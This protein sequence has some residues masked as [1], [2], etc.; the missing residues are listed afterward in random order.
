MH[1]KYSNTQIQS[2]VTNTNAILILNCAVL[3]AHLCSCNLQICICS[4]KLS[5]V[6]ALAQIIILHAVAGIHCLVIC[7]IQ[8]LTPYIR[9]VSALEVLRNRV[10]QIDIYLLTY[11]LVKCRTLHVL[12]SVSGQIPPCKFTPDRPRPGKVCP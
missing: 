4:S 10:L 8:L 9:N 6:Q 1:F 2:A 3:T 11:L 7:G 5:Y 12:A